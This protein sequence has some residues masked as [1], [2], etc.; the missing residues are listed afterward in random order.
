MWTVT[1][2]LLLAISNIICVCLGFYLGRITQGK[3]SGPAMPR[4][5]P[6][7]PAEP[8]QDL[9]YEAMH[10]EDQQTIPTVEDTK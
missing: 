8:D 4:I 9:Y 7:K 2:A 3:A 1:D 10:G 6:E 5:F